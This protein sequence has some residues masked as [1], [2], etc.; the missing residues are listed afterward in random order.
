[1]ANVEKYLDT[2]SPCTHIQAYSVSRWAAERYRYRIY[3]Y[4]AEYIDEKFRE[5]VLA[6]ALVLQPF[7]DGTLANLF[8]EGRSAN[9]DVYGRTLLARNAAGETARSYP[10][11]SRPSTSKASGVLSTIPTKALFLDE[12]TST[13]GFKLLLLNCDGANTNRKAVRMLTAELQ[14]KKNLL[15]VVNYCSAH[16]VNNA[17]KWGL[18][19]FSYGNLIRG[20]HVLQTA[21]RRK[22]EDH[23]RTYIREDIQEDPLVLTDTSVDYAK[24]VW[25][26][27][28]GVFK[29]PITLSPVGNDEE[30]PG[31][32]SESHRLWKQFVRLITGAKGP[33]AT[34]GKKR[35]HGLI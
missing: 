16:G 15:V 2:S 14:P 8:E 3:G 33:F 21:K 30:G 23:V 32:I 35:I 4:G 10:V 12:L 25:G 24:A 17:A 1:M 5:F 28:G 27:Y 34:S 31:K 18:G 19:V 9:V 26:E 6:N 11:L 7:H 20:C 22:F 29:D 13:P